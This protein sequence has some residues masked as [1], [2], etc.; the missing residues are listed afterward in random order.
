I[1]SPEAAVSYLQRQEY[2][3]RLGPA[4]L[5][6]M[7][8][9]FSRKLG[10]PEKQDPAMLPLILEAA[11]LCR[12]PAVAIAG[13]EL[14]KELDG[15]PATESHLERICRWASETDLDDYGHEFVREIRART[16]TKV[17]DADL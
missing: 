16:Y 13:R 1:L 6:P 2:R 14:T 12:D 8:L 10:T 17:D 9:E 7:L 11:K 3:V 4:T 5:R 15:D